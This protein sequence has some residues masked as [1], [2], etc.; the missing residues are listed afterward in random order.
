M[1]YQ[2]PLAYLLGL[3]GLALLRAWAGDHDRAFVEAR[4]AEV[5]RL[6][7]DEELSAHPGVEVEAGA[8]DETYRQWAASYDDPGNGLF[9]L[10]A[11]FVEAVCTGLPAGVAL[12]AG[13]GTGRLIPPL[14]ARGH[15]VVGVDASPAMLAHARRR[16]PEADLLVGDLQDLPLADGAVDL[17]VTG[18]ALTHVDDLGGALAELARVLRPGGHLVV[19]DVHHELVLR[20]SAPKTEG[21]DGR[22]RMATVRRHT[23]GDFLRAGLAAGL[24]LRDFDEQPHPAEPDEPL[25]APTRDIG[26]W[27]D[28]PWT[29]VGLVPEATRSAWAAPAVVLFHFER[30]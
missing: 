19:S 23:V 1:T 25:P 13:C 8:T 10:D 16:A 21:S 4:L 9:D 12:D 5:R 7:A 29:L 20:G 3:E 26:P 14:L 11:P 18:L 24:I 2:H 28:W 27:R 22:P 15:R 6:L 30:G 17:V